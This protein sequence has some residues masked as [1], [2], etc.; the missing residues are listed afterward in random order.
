MET[1]DEIGSTNN[2]P[3]QRLMRDPFL[4]PKERERPFM[5]LLIL[6]FVVDKFF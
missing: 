4:N 5:T 1:I 2:V 3:F 6:G